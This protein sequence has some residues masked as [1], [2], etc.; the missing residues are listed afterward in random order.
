MKKQ[1]YIVVGASAFGKHLV[2][3]L[4][5]MPIEV[6]VMDR[7]PKRLEEVADYVLNTVC[8]DAANPEVLDQLSIPSFDGAVVDTGHDLERK[9]LITMQLKERGVPNIIVKANNE[10]EGRVLR[11]LGADHVIQPDR[12]IGIR[13]AHQIAGDKYFEAI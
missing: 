10:L 13:V 9:A 6:L 8:A 7:D 11:R 5:G 4:S 2:R 1:S 3:E 12:E